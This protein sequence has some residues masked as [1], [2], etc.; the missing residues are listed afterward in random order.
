MIGSFFTLHA[1][2]H[3]FLSVAL[4]GLAFGGLMGSQGALHH[5]VVG[6][7]YS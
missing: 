1:Y 7:D 2:L 6:I 4:Y 3:M 5:G